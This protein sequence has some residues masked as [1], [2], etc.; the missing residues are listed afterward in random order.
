V[1]GLSLF[2]SYARCVLDGPPKYERRPAGS[3]VD[4]FEPRIRE[5]LPLD[6]TIVVMETMDTVPAQARRNA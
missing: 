1:S 4:A 3:S 6:E 2:R 5:L